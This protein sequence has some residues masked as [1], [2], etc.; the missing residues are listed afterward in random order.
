MKQSYTTVQ[1][2]VFDLGGTYLRCGLW[3]YSGRISSLRRMK[4]ENFLN[5]LG[6]PAIWNS[7]ICRIEDYHTSVAHWVPADAPIVVSFPGPIQNRRQILSAPTFLGKDT[8]IPDLV[9]ELEERTGRRVYI[10]N[11]V[12]AAAWH[13]SLS[14]PVDRFMVITISSGIGSKIFDRSRSAGVIDSPAWAGE[15][16]HMV[17]DDSLNAPSCDCGGLGHLGAIASGRG[18]ERAARRH[19]CADPSAF[20]RSACVTKFGGTAYSLNNEEHIVP[21]ALSGDLWCL[22]VVRQATKPLARVILSV[23]LG[24]G[25]E[26]VTMIGGFA[27]SL[28]SVYL[29]IL[30][31]ELIAICRYS[32]LN[33]RVGS[34]VE[35]GDG[36][37]EACLMGAGAFAQRLLEVPR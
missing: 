24:A 26:R 14:T 11:D 22:D 30:R 10:I 25:I 2:L 15:I 36:C 28:G 32:V 9:G 17:V 37:E 8:S 7:L 13:L 29:Q 33:D 20:A 35:L 27:L 12:S 21:A 31:E 5:G 4:V 3:D 34:L 1:A 23:V 19:A 6:L 16:G 18:V